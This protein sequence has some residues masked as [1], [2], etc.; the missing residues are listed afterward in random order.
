MKTNHRI[1]LLLSGWLWLL[2]LQAQTV[3]TIQVAQG[4]SY[5][6]HISLKED[7]KDMDLMV[8]FVF[9]E[10][11]NT[12]TVTLIS[13]RMLYVFW[14]NVRY[15]PLIKGRTLRPDQLPYVVDAKP[16]DKYKVSKF[17]RATVPEPREDFFFQRWINY[18]GLQPVPQEYKMVND[19]ISQPFDI[20]NKR[21]SVTIWLHDIFLMDKIEKKKYNRY[22]IP[23]GRDLN[24]LYQ[25]NIV[26]N[27]CFGLDEDVAAAKNALDGVTKNYASFKSKYSSGTLG[28]EEALKLFEELKGTLQGQFQH[29]EVQSDCPDIQNA[30]D[31]YNH[32]VD[33][34][35]SI[36]CVVLTAEEAA[37]KEG[38]T[39]ES[40]TI[41]M[42]KARQIDKMVSRWLISKEPL[43]RHDLETQCENLITEVN[44]MIGKSGGHTA[45][46]REAIATFRAAERYYQRTCKQKLR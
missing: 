14:D 10:E 15:K 6:D 31:E 42:S 3:R 33:S 36:K 26:R 46:Q 18:D 40:L 2:G 22:E 4:T 35:S 16:K 39:P 8:K 41:L 19:F 34:I 32:Y 7:S 30:W 5:T 23:F 12:L 25:V 11:K 45:E 38:L 1:V 28:S 9:D 21:T 43:E 29:K 24:L 17:F 20:Q 44:D 13:Y 37:A 27:P